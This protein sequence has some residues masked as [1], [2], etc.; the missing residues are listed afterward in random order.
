MAIATGLP[1]QAYTRDTLVKAIE[2]LT[3]QPPNVKERATTA[4]A[5]VSFYLQASRKASAL[6]EAPLSGEAF[7]AD[8][9]TLA[10]DLKLFE[11]TSA[12]PHTP[13][14]SFAPIQNPQALPM[15]PPPP[16]IPP[17]HAPS[18]NHHPMPPPPPVAPTPL[19]TSTASIAAAP[20]SHQQEARGVVVWNVDP[21]SLLAAKEIQERFNLG[22]EI[23]A[24]RMLVTLGIERSRELFR[25]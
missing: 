1:P 25:P 24:L 8:L 20:P 21:R 11:D 2:W 18:A 16:Y 7:K 14:R 4:D 23:E 9:K 10:E 13:L 15:T 12:P 6:Q 22:S 3:S 19:A 17:S 5:I